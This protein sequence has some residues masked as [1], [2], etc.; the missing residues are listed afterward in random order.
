MGI[1]DREYV[2]SNPSPWSGASAG[3]WSVTT[4]IIVACIVV[5]VLQVLARNPFGGL[6]RLSAYLAYNTEVT[7]AG[8]QLWRLLTYGFC[9]EP[10]GMGHLFFNMLALYFT[11]RLVEPVYGARRFLA[12]YLLA[13]VAS[14][15]TTTA[16]DLMLYLTQGVVRSTVLIGASGGCAAVFVAAALMFPHVKFLLFFVIPVELRW[17]ALGYL[18]ITAFPILQ[19]FGGHIQQDGISHAGHLG[20]M[21]FG[22]VFYRFGSGVP[23]PSLAPRQWWST[24]SRRLRRPELKVY[25]EEP[26]TP[27]QPP[28]PRRGIDAAEMDRLLEKVGREGLDSLTAAEKERLAAASR[29]LRSRR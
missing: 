3:G 29:E 15:L 8:L 24:L 7:F 20:G 12:F 6:D 25:R 4:K 14:A 17:L 19:E 18:A 26:T 11:G 27:P 21:L 28:P 16:I 13:I 23:I 1:Y 10:S 2:R 9:H 22:Y 5:F